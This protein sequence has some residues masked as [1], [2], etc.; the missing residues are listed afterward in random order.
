MTAKSFQDLT[1]A[2]L[3]VFTTSLVK[4]LSVLV[5]NIMIQKIVEAMPK[6]KSKCIKKLKKY[7]KKNYTLEGCY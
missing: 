7:V 3:V 6:A 5:I 1:Q 2:P 4:K